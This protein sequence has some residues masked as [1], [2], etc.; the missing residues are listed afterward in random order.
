MKPYGQRKD[1]LRLWWWEKEERKNEEGKWWWFTVVEEGK[2]R[3]NKEGK[4][5]GGRRTR[6]RVVWD[7]EKEVALDGEEWLKTFARD[8][9]QKAGEL[10]VCGLRLNC[11]RRIRVT[12]DA[13]AASFMGKVLGKHVSLKVLEHRIHSLWKLEFGYTP[14]VGMMKKKKTDENGAKTTK[15]KAV[16]KAA[17][18]TTDGRATYHRREKRD[19]PL[20]ASGGKFAH[21]CVDVDLR[22][23]LILKIQ[24]LHKLQNVDYEALYLVHLKIWV[25]KDRFHSALRSE[26]NELGDMIPESDEMVEVTKGFIHK[27]KGEEEHRIDNFDTF[28]S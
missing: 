13:L 10:N 3:K 18:H 28:A 22:K 4:G 14:E 27:I 5:G 8:G 21:I 11:I 23:P 19:F 26:E 7:R 20:R 12:V 17:A 15:M 2:R 16:G 9:L 25:E 1:Y 6:G 24:I